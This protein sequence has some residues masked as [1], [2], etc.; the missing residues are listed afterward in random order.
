MPIAILFRLDLRFEIQSHPDYLAFE[1]YGAN[2]DSFMGLDM[3]VVAELDVPYKFVFDSDRKPAT[4]EF[5]IPENLNYPDK[6]FL[7]RVLH[8]VHDMRW[9]YYCKSY[10]ITMNKQMKEKF[11]DGNSHILLNRMV[12]VDGVIIDLSFPD[13]LFQINGD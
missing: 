13:G 11:W 9:T 10:A 5:F 8:A 12:G 1:K 3:K 6:W 4:Y 2:R 7:S